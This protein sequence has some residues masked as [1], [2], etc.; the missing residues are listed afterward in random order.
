M[1]TNHISFYSLFQFQKLIV[2]Y[3]FLIVRD[4]FLK[5]IVYDRL[6]AIYQS[7]ANVNKAQ[8]SLD[9]H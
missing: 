8:K 6:I 7:V 1:S 3:P 4:N 2:S 5:G 9:S